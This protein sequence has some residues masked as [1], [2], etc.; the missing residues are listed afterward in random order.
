MTSLIARS[1]VERLKKEGASNGGGEG[2]QLPQQEEEEEALY[3]L[4]VCSGG[5]VGKRSG[6]GEQVTLGIVVSQLPS[7]SSSP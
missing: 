1:D 2:Q 5:E 3:L 6:K 4:C 7:S